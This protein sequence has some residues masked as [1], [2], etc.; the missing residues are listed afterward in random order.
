LARPI[1]SHV[2]VPLFASA[3]LFFAGHVKADDVVKCPG[4]DGANSSLA[5]VDAR[6]RLAFVR[7]VMDDQARRAR[8]WHL[9]WIVAGL[10]LSAG[11]YTR[12]ALADTRDERIDPLVGGTTALFI[13]A[14][15]LALPLAVVRHQRTVEEDAGTLSPAE[16][17]RGVCAVLARAER[18]FAMSAA[19][20]AFKAGIAAHLFVIGGN[21]A[22]AL[23]L[24]LG[25]DHWQ[26]ALV[27][28]GGGLL[29][30][31]LRIFTQPTGAITEL[32][33][34][35]RGDLHAVAS[36]SSSPIQ[37]APWIAQGGAGIAAFGTF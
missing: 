3:W 31:E 34:Y 6:R 32:A 23:F 12:A 11:N 9:A 20:E 28:G 25:F 2:L 15:T 5:D 1:V 35:R 27:N 18:L 29:I 19:D 24:G 14:S 10:G 16:G 8:R 22:I 7:D 4:V 13:P 26:G 33:R 36:P 30:S 17:A 37:I 21:G